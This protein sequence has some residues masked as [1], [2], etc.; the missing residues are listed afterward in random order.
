MIDTAKCKQTGAPDEGSVNATP[1]QFLASTP[2][3][4]D[5][6]EAAGSNVETG[7][8]FG[9]AASRIPRETAPSWK[10]QG[11]RPKCRHTRHGGKG[12]S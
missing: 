6:R 8:C 10:R 7:G 12:H 2:S 11:R 5:S 9:D 3:G 1:D 4:N